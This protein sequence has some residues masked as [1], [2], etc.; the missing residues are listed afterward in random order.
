MAG[1]IGSYKIAFSPDLSSFRGLGRQI[2]EAIGEAPLKSPAITPPDTSAITSAVKKAAEGTGTIP[3]PKIGAPDTS[4]F[5]K[6]LQG[7]KSKAEPILSGISNAFGKL[8]TAG[9]VGLA[10]AVAGVTAMVPAALEASDSIDDFKASMQFAGIP[11]KEYN[12]AAEAANKY[13]NATE[14]DLNDLLQTSAVLGANGVKDFESMAEAIGGFNSAAGGTAETYGSVALVMG[15]AAAQGKIMTGDWNQLINAVPTGAHVLQNALKGAGAYTGDFRDALSKGEISANELFA[16]VK[17]LGSSDIAQQAATSSTTF[18]GAWANATAEVQTQLR[19]TF[20]SIKPELTD[21]INASIPIIDAI[22]PKIG[23]ALSWIVGAAKNFFDFIKQNKGTLEPLSASASKFGDSLKTIA[24]AITAEIKPKIGPAL[25]WLVGAIKGVLDF[26]N[27]NK[28]TIAEIAADI[29]GFVTGAISAIGPIIDQIGPKIGDAVKFALDAIK[30]LFDFIKR[31]KDLVKSLTAGIVGFVAAAK[32]I[33]TVTSVVNGVKTAFTALKEAGSIIT[34]VK[35]AWT[36]LSAAFSLSPIGLVITLIAALVAALVWFFTQTETGR[37]MWSD[38]TATMSNAWQSFTQWVSG[39]GPSI[40]NAW[41]SFTT[42]LSNA[43]T[44]FGQWCANIV[45]GLSQFVASVEQF[46]INLGGSIRNTWN[47]T[48]SAVG[49]F[50][51]SIWNGIKNSFSSAAAWLVNAMRGL[52]NGV[53]GAFNGA[54]SWLVSAGKNLINGLWNGIKS[55]AGWLWGKLTG[56]AAKIVGFVKK[57][58]KIHSPSRVF[59]D[60]IG[61][62]LSQGIGVGLMAGA[63]TVYKQAGTMAR[64]L[65]STL[66]VSPEASWS[67]TGAQQHLLAAQQPVALSGAGYGMVQPQV[68][69]NQEVSKADSLID[70]YLQTKK[71]AKG[72]FYR[73]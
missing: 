51:Y 1:T 5:D 47:S 36:A 49:S 59:R 18:R 12:A 29:T 37:K 6:A 38:F 32:T 50:F 27:K 64:R 9:K 15:Q 14:Y 45:I 63:P 72:Y 39:I 21:A 20:D 71:A 22:G 25:K 30:N 42:T 7:L 23:D 19:N 48:W 56:L 33:Q 28:D 43:W 57:I 70:V 62:Y 2:Q 69:I 31:N 58:F 60:E 26:V 10:G 68:T 61:I 67:L 11:E 66:S 54:G 17:K 73:H 13:A 8:K 46:F 53:V 24:S 55:G 16:A 44:S 41:Q 65:V 34:I 52:K 40:S 35:N 3:G 4:L